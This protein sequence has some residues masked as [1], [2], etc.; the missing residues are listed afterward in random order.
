[1]PTPIRNFDGIAA[2]GSFCPGCVVPDVSGEP[3]ATQYVQSVNLAYQVFDKATGNS[4]LG[5]VSITSLW[6]G[7]GTCETQTQGWATVLYDQLADRWVIT[8]A[9]GTNTF[10]PSDV[11]FAIS[12]TNDATGSYYR[13][14]FHFSNLFAYPKFGVWPDGYYM[15]AYSSTTQG[16]DLGQQAFAFDRVVMLL[17]HP[18]SALTL[19]PSGT[20]ILFSISPVDLDGSTLPPSGTACPFIEWAGKGQ[21]RTFLFHSDFSVPANTTFTERPGPTAGPFNNICGANR[22]C[23]P[24]AGTTNKLAVPI[25]EFMHRLTYRIVGGVERVVGSFP[26]ASNSVAGVRWFE[27][28]NVTSGVETLF[29]EGTYQPDTDW[30]WMSSAAQDRD[31]NMAL[32]FSAS[33][34]AINPQIRYAGRLANDPINTLAQGEAHLFDGTGSQTGTNNNRWGESNALT[35]DPVDDCTF[36]FTNEYYAVNSVN[37]WRTRIGSFKFP[38]CGGS[39]TPSISGTVHYGNPS[40]GPTPRFVSNV[41]LTAEGSNTVVATSDPPGATAG[42][43]VLTGFGAGAYAVTPTKTAGTNN[44]SSFD[45]ALIAL[46]VAGPPNP[47]LNANQLIAADVS[48]NNSVTSFDAGMIAKFVAGPPYAAPGI[49][50][51]STWKFN[52]AGRTYPS[53][54]GSI[55]G[56][57]YLAYLMGEVSGN[58]TNTGVRPAA[59][60]G[61]DRNSTVS[62]P[63]LLTKTGGTVV[64]PV[65]LQGM[66]GKGIISY[67]FTLR[68]DPSVI[69]PQAN[70]LILSATASDGRFAA[71]NS[72]EPGILRVAVYGTAPLEANSLLLNL[73]FTVVGKPSTTSP[74]TWERFMFNETEVRPA[75]GRVAVR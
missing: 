48:G 64:V 11:C 51:T 22:N 35:I 42:Q 18:A 73:K 29:Q 67:E 50:S 49:G 68:Y 46:H 16:V 38:S 21:Y 31:G 45:A 60:R 52:P 66:M 43:Y 65:R 9:A 17:G 69:S 72:S 58:W 12:T 10:G 25:G 28:R 62:A 61:A 7:F 63:T 40:S 19:G 71:Y 24:Q 26:V 36:W 70:P 6:S 53:I 59:V 44:I 54:A 30:R 15:S 13:Y 20:N 4:L 75:A 41:T 27:L 32:G 47:Q 1:M 34:A 57:D 2:T 55:V 56:E 33:S 8:M 39:V 14:D 23:V 37:S 74:L 3:G 5:P